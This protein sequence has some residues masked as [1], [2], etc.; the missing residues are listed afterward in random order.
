M[1]VKNFIHV[2]SIQIPQYSPFTSK[3]K[4]CPAFGLE[5]VIDLT[6]PLSIPLDFRNPEVPVGFDG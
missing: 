2:K 5:V 4:H 6:V 3:S 1:V